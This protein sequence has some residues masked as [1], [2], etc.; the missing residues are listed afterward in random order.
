MALSLVP[1]EITGRPRERP[2]TSVVVRLEKSAMLRF[3]WGHI[4]G[5]KPFF[6]FQGTRKAAGHGY[7]LFDLELGWLWLSAYWR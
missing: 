7:R 2:V 3:R 4:Q 6:S 1:M 5:Y